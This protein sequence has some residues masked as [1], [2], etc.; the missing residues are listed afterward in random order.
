MPAHPLTL[1]RSA[2]AAAV[3]RPLV[4]LVLGLVLAALLATGF[5]WSATS[6]TVLLSVDGTE[7]EVDFRGGT[8]E[9][10]LAAAGLEAGE[11]DV[12]VPAAGTPVEDGD[13]VALRRARELTLVVDG[14]ERTV[15]VT[16]S[17]VEEALDQIGLRNGS[18]ALSASRSR[19]LPLDGFRLA[20]TT[21]KDISILAD[22]AVQ[23]LTTTAAT[24]RDALMEAGISLDGDDRISDT[25]STPVAHHMVIRVTRVSTA[26]TTETVP[27]AFKT[28]RREDGDLVKGET[29]TLRAGKPG[30]V[31]RTVETVHADGKLEKRS[32]VA[33]TTV[34]APVTRVLA[35]GTKARPAQT[36]G[37]ARRGTGSADGLNWPALAD[38]ESG[39]NPRAVNPTGKYRG[40]Y[41]FSMETWR[42]VGGSGDP[43]DNSAGEQT[44][45][46]KLLYQR[47]GA[48]Q[49]PHCGKYLFS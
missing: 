35:V 21:P 27:V 31:R 6:P 2:L 9:D 28:E 37:S 41:Q 14:K 10:V 30:M 11:R 44:Y 17:S 39:G 25:R 22:N 13:R 48:G 3:R 26:R 43:I 38:C 23:P 42:G 1:S 19:E 46:A 34:S 5:A 32:V 49:W 45:R 40:L 18:L 15:W 36:T 20:V 47:S 7:Q 33:S 12:L 4:P 24:V 8:V 16:A 29:R